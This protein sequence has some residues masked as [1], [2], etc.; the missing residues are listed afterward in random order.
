MAIQREKIALVTG[1]SRGIG[2]AVA[3][4]L[5]QEGYRVCL[6]SRNEKALQAVAEE[7]ID[8]FSIP[9]A[10][11]PLIYACDVAN[12]DQVNAAV[13]DIIQKCG[14][15]DVLLNNAG[16]MRLGT[17]ENQMH[18]KEL[19]EI[20]LVGAFNILHATVPHMKKRQRGHIFILSSLC[21]KVGF[22]GVGAYTA[23]KFGLIGLAESLFSELAPHH[24]KV[25][26]L[27]PSYV[28]TQMVAHVEYPPADLMIAPHDIWLIMRG[29][30]SLSQAAC[31]REVI[32]QC[33]AVIP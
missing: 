13:E 24:V 5:A 14:H 28:A 27:C 32:I 20:N 8:T 10:Q 21:G 9:D 16:I 12:A 2:K 33:E 1:A 15:I 23:T 26:S 30:L 29:L 4:G 18:F 17:I 19:L 6:L 7:M 11:K 25:T 31:V 3:L 22:A